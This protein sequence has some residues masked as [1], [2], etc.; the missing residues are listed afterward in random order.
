MS[1]YSLNGSNVIPY[2]PGKTGVKIQYGKAGADSTNNYGTVTFPV[3]FNSPP[4]VTT[5]M[6]QGASTLSYYVCIESV[7]ASSFGYRR[8]YN[9]NSLALGEEF[10]WIAIGI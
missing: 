7:N 10:H 5:G 4:I 2:T 8:F 1:G 3:S 6:T 9:N